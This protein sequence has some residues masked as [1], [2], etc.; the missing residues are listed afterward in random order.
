MGKSCKKSGSSNDTTTRSL[1]TSSSIDPKPLAVQ[2]PNPN[3]TKQEEETANHAP[4]VSSYNERIRPLL[5]AVDDLRRLNIMKEGIQ[6]PTIVVVGDH[7]A[8]NMPEI[9]KQ[10]NDKLNASVLEFNNM[11]KVMSSPAEAMTTFMRVIGLTKDSLRKLFLRGEFEEYPDDKSMHSTARLAEMLNRFSDKLQK[12]A[13]QDLTKDFL[14]EE[15]G[16]LEESKSIGLPNF[17]PRNAFLVVLQK[18]VDSV[19]KLPV[20]FIENVWDYIEE[21]VLTVLMRHSDNYYHLQM[22]ARRAANNFITRLKEQS[23]NRVME[24]VEMEKYVDYTCNPEYMTEWTKLFTQQEIFFQVLGET[25]KYSQVDLDGFGIIK[26]NYLR[27]YTTQ[28]VHQ[29]FD[30]KM[31]MTAYWKIVLRRIV[32]N[33]ALH[34]QFSLQNLVDKEMEATIVNELM[35]PHCGGLER[36]MAESPAVAGKREKLSRSINLLRKSKAVVAKIM[37]NFHVSND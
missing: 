16:I 35:D 27:K 31:R 12:C 19:S 10:I 14:A 3:P 32:D 1:V 34:L 7:I 37:D 13:E 21:I 23:I 30:L 6:L 33:M 20:E 26:V 29:A 4:I 17:L 11:P 28:V 5:D 24:I 36:M 25:Q 18:E 22:S 15:L 9:V 2:I 8:R